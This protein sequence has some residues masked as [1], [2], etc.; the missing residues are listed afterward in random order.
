M[1]AL[2]L[3]A[4]LR[5]R[6]FQLFET[7][8][9]GAQRLGLLNHAQAVD[10]LALLVERDATLVHPIHMGVGVDP[11]WPMPRSVARPPLSR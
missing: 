1:K 10:P 4:P 6:R 8:L 11:A 5:L 2:R 3:D 7:G 9:E